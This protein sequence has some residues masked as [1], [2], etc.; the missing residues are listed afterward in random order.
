MG[1]ISD[2]VVNA[3][4]K[5][6]NLRLIRRITSYIASFVLMFS[7]IPGL[8]ESSEAELI[9]EKSI[10]TTVSDKELGKAEFGEIQDEKAET[11]EDFLNDVSK[12]REKESNEAALQ[13]LIELNC[14]SEEEFLDQLYS[15]I[16]YR[17]PDKYSK[18]EKD[19]VDAG[20]IHRFT[21]QNP[22]YTAQRN[23]GSLQAILF[24]YARHNGDF[25][26]ADLCMTQRNRE[27]YDA[28]V[29]PIIKITDEEKVSD[30]GIMDAYDRLTSGDVKFDDDITKK[31]Y[32]FTA[33]NTLLI[34]MKY[35]YDGKMDLTS[36][37]DEVGE[38]MSDCSKALELYDATENM[39]MSQ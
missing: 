17:N 6:K 25:D 7:S 27:M 37:I 13:D 1:K 8:A 28:I 38:I 10:S 23:S 4:T 5:I 3:K 31:V 39:V 15:L 33:S 16:Y 26:M 19:L 11:V 12:W 34:C 14:M 24:D 36:M 32:E 21:N 30:K 2:L 20:I 22:L 29:A 18:I 35:E 9:N